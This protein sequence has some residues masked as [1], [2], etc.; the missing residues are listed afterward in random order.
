MRLSNCIVKES[1]TTTEATVVY[2]SNLELDNQDLQALC[3]LPI[4]SLQLD[5]VAFKAG[6]NVQ[7]H[8]SKLITL[9]TLTIKN[10]N[11]ASL[12]QLSK[13]CS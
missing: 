4:E 5:S 2:L 10:A 8:L 1:I 7:Y 13:L 11:Y 3:L 9:K 12:C 6:T